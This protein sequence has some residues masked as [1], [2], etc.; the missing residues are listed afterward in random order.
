M[1]RST[2]TG[3]DTGTDPMPTVIEADEA[4]EI[5]KG[6]KYV[7]YTGQATVRRITRRE[8]EK[9]GVGKQADVEWTVRNRHLVP[10]E[11]LTDA[12]LQRLESEH[13][14]RVV[15]GSEVS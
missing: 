3:E 9:A 10:V 12:A 13:G 11:D 1:A 6:K 8:W 14:F 7:H 15:S 5:K 2:T 4:I